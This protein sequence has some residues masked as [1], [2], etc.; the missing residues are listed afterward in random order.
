MD[1]AEYK[2]KWAGDNPEKIKAA[3]QKWLSANPEKRKQVN[4]EWARRNSESVLAWQARNPEKVRAAKKAWAE[5]NKTKRRAHNA[6][7]TALKK[8]TLIRQ[9]LCEGC[10]Q[11]CLGEKAIHAHHD[12]YAEPLAIRWFCPTCH[13]EWHNINGKAR[14]GF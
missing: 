4:R 2:K 12:D 13:N 10:G 11:E 9:T 6:V 3:Q 8:G 14:N 1:I 5:R 7:Q